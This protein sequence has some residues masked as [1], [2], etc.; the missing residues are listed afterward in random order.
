M[1]IVKN[2][3]NMYH[4]MDMERQMHQFHRVEKNMDYH[5]IWWDHLLTDTGVH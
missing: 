2:H 5:H 3:N 4:L 1:Y